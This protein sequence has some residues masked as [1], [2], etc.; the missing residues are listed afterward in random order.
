MIPSS[1]QES[2][3]IFIANDEGD[4]IGSQERK[5]TFRATGHLN[6]LPKYP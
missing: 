6:I 1:V 2:E 5:Q 4:A 3:A